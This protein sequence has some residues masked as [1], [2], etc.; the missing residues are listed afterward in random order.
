MNFYELYKR[1]GTNE[2]LFALYSEK[3][4]ACTLSEFFQKLEDEEDSYYNA[5][6][7]VKEDLLGLGLIKYRYNRYKERVIQLTPKGVKIVRILKEINVL[8]I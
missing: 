5:F 1:R 7:R 2:T 4:Y 3:N 8:F 6:F